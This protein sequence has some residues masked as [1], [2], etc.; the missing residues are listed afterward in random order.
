MDEVCEW[1]ASGKAITHLARDMD[2]SYN[3][4]I[5]WVNTDDERAR[6]YAHA[7][8]DQADTFADEI[9]TLA[10]GA[11]TESGEVNKARLQIDARK[12]VASKLKPKRYGDK[13][14]IEQNLTVTDLT[15]EQLNARLEQLISK[16][17]A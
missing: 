5:T 11:G 17:K 7:R 13:I 4:L 10:D 16:P 1:I 14:E 3:A 12:W 15:D 8:D 6:R 9:V 2:I